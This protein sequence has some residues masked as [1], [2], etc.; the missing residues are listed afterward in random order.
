MSPLVESNQD[1]AA[2]LALAAQAARPGTLLGRQHF[3]FY[4]SVLQGVSPRAAGDRY[5]DLEDGAHADSVLLAVRDELITASRRGGRAVDRRL[6]TLGTV[7]PDKPA[8]P[9]L[10]DFR[11]RVDPKGTF[12]TEKGLQEIYKQEYRESPHEARRRR[13]QARQLDAL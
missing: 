9:S 5:L 7:A 11:K 13:F 4:R 10:E 3:A 6:W 8:T 1:L 2:D 12:Y